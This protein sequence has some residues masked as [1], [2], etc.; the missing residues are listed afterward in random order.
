[1]FGIA[2]EILKKLIAM[3]VVASQLMDRGSHYR[4]DK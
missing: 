1:L 2:M 3:Y 4:S